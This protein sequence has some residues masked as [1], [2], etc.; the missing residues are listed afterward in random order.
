MPSSPEPHHP[1]TARKAAVLALV[2]ESQFLATHQAAALLGI[3]AK[4]ARDHLLD[5][6]RHGL[7]ESERTYGPDMGLDAPF[8]PMVHWVTPAGR[9]FLR[10]RGMLP[11]GAG[12]EPSYGPRSK[13]FVGH[14][15]AVRDLLV[16]LTVSARTLSAEGHAVAQWSVGQGIAFGAARPD[17]A[18][19]YRVAGEPRPASVVGVLE[20]DMG[21]QT[22]ADG[23]RSDRWAQKLKAYGE[24]YAAAER[25]GDRAAHARLVVTVGT[26]AR[27]EWV[28]GRLRESGAVARRAWVAVR[29]DLGG[30]GG[31]TGVRDAV[32]LRPDGTRA[33]FAPG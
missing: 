10:R 26:A 1:V 9:R 19:V 16:W 31:W 33:A 4:G 18:F 17:A 3:T 13:G 6:R 30:D 12:R 14:E 32:W 22:A 15:A 27:A 24:A 29:G 21:T 5:L 25:T 7:L 28:V 11:E 20:C 8:G 23:G 2:A